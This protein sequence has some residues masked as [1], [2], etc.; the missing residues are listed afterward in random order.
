L[1]SLNY[2]LDLRLSL[3]PYIVNALMMRRRHALDA[4]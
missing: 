2:H 1:T 3:N 4:R